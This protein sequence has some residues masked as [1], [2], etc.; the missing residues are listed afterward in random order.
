M[1]GRSTSAE[2]CIDLRSAA[3]CSD[4]CALQNA[5]SSA[6]ERTILVASPS[7][8]WCR[9]LSAPLW[10]EERKG[11]ATTGI[12]CLVFHTPPGGTRRPFCLVTAPGFPKFEPAK[13]RGDKG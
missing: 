2:Q 10:P 6:D 1:P 12:A 7:A 13:V 8:A 3:P 9:E 4:A 11:P 5:W